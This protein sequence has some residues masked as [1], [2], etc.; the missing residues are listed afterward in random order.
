MTTHQP[1]GA[2]FLLGYARTGP[3]PHDLDGQIDALSDAGI[4]PARIYSD[5][6]DA[7]SPAAER[8]GWA[9][10]LSYARPGD[11]TVVVGIDRLGRS[12]PEVLA[13]ARELTTRHI[14]LRSLREG[15]DTQDPAGSMLV[16]VLASL[17]ELDDEARLTRRRPGGRRPH[18]STVGRP[19]ALDEAQIAAA[20][21][22]RAAGH[23]VPEIASELGVS[24]ATLYRTLADRKAAQ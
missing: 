10:L 18:A 24:R 6:A 21:R 22:M 2:P 5:K 14:G 9:A 3:G 16:G 20:E 11:T 12:T 19:R 1:V 7:S 8:P 4:E 23:R 15:L 17:A 13:S